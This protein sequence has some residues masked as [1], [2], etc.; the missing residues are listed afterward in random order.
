LWQWCSGSIRVFNPDWGFLC[1]FII[2]NFTIPMTV[3]MATSILVVG[4]DLEVADRLQ[5]VLAGHAF[6]T[7]IATNSVVG[8]QIAREKRPDLILSDL[9]HGGSPA[10]RKQSDNHDLLKQVRHHRETAN[11]PVILLAGEAEFEDMQF[12]LRL[13]ADDY[14]RKPF[15]I[16]DL[17]R[18]IHLCLEKH[19]R[20]THQVQQ[21]EQR[22]A[23]LE[24]QLKHSQEQN[25]LY[26]AVLD[27]FSYD[28]RHPLGNVSI[29]LQ[30]LK[31]QAIPEE[32]QPF[33]PLLEEECLHGTALL[34]ELSNVQEMIATSRGQSLRRMRAIEP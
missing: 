16:R 5:A 20:L 10:R 26:G 8:L 34:D 29:A 24:K 15:E 28:L 32:L 9:A 25:Q 18:A 33:F 11:I 17:L 23:E 27:R 30:L 1:G 6:D 19:S 21:Q 4:S 13:G 3:D 14:V 31:Q 22:I 12:G 7:L 2:Y